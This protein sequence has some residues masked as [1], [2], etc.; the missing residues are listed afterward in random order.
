MVTLEMRLDMKFPESVWQDQ[1]TKFREI[2][3][4]S[5]LEI[6]EAELITGQLTYANRAAQ[7]TLG[8]TREEMQRLKVVDLLEDG[9]KHLFAELQANVLVKGIKEARSEYKIKTKTGDVVST[10]TNCRVSDEADSPKRVVFFCRDLTKSKMLE[11]ELW[12]SQKM[13]AIGTLAA[14]VAHDFNNLLMV[15]QKSVSLLT[16]DIEEGHPHHRLLKKMDQAVKAGADI[17]RKLIG[18][19][20]GPPNTETGFR[21][22]FYDQRNR[23]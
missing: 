17:T 5:P 22:V 9:S 3:D 19:R 21:T 7:Q 14:G 16:N 15:I 11:S 20:D 2:V 10:L 1:L 6:F 4:Y 23:P 8:Y 13:E 12:K 18:D